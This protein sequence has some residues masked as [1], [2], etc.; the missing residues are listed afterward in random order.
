VVLRIDW[1]ALRGGDRVLVHHAI[2]DEVR[3]V[4]GVVTA[5]TAVGGSNDIEVRVTTHRGQRVIHP[6]R[7]SVH[8]DP[9]EY[10][11]HCWRCAAL[12]PPTTTTVPKR[13]RA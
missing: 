5:V 7:L 3:L 1:N 6:P 9:I 8:H 13:R 10:D 4:A 12:E 2:D 11:G